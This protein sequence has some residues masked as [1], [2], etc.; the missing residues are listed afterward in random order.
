MEDMEFDDI[1]LYSRYLL[2]KANHSLFKARKK[3]LRPFH[4]SPQQATALFLVDSLGRQATLTEIARHTDRGVN[5]ISP[6]MST[7]EKDGLVKKTRI[8]PKSTLLSFKLTAKGLKTF[9]NTHKSQSIKDIMSI[10]SDKEQKQLVL[11]LQK[12]I[13]NAE[14]Y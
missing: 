10:L 9:Q 3:E 12:I 5:S 4:I 2:G 1:A 13:N 14:K 11:I 6:Q 7:L 8:E